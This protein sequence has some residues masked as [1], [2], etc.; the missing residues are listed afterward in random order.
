MK[1]WLEL[2]AKASKKRRHTKPFSAIISIGPGRRSPL[3][4]LA[5]YSTATTLID[6]LEKENGSGFRSPLEGCGV[7]PKHPYYQSY[8]LSALTYNVKSSHKC[9]YSYDLAR[10]HR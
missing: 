9:L 3:S 7:G 8:H 4:E 1:R 6:L 2:A 10:G 5:I